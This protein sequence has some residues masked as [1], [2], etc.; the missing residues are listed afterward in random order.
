MGSN[1]INEQDAGGWTPLMFASDAGHT[2]AVDRLLEARADVNSESLRSCTALQL[3]S[4]SG[5]LAVVNQL[6]VAKAD[7]NAYCVSALDTRMLN[8]ALDYARIKKE[9]VEFTELLLQH[10]AMIGPE[11]TALVNQEGT[12][13][14]AEACHRSAKWHMHF[15]ERTSTELDLPRH[16]MD[17]I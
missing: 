14:H 2:E 6:L 3:A 12:D 10:G 4:R 16:A 5:K 1:D 7:V 11:V 17:F 15:L 9:S 8:T 13:A